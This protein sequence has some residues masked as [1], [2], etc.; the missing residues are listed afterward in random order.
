[1]GVSTGMFSTTAKKG[2]YEPNNGLRHDQANWRVRN[3]AV[4]KGAWNGRCYL[5]F[6]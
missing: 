3:A 4:L 2:V 1:M 6:P 5:S